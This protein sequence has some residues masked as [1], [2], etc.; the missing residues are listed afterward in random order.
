M[1]WSRLVVL[2]VLSAC[3][4]ALGAAPVAPAAPANPCLDPVQRAALRCPDLHMS[5]PFDLKLD[6]KAVRGRVVLRAGNSINSVGAGPAE[7]HGVR[8]S[9]YRM[10]ARQR[11]YKRGGGRIAVTTGAGLYFKH[12]PGQGRYWKWAHA[13]RFELWRRDSTGTRTK[14]VRVGP[15]A[16]Y[17]L[18]DLKHTR[19]RLTR[20]PRKARYPGCNRS[21]KTRRITLGTSVGWSDVYPASYPEQWIDVTG[22]RGCFDYEHIADPGN[23]IFES[24]EDN[25]KGYVTVRLPFKP[26][27]QNCP[28]RGVQAPPVPSPAP[29]PDP[30][31]Y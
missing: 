13:A 25:N 27:R 7:L 17:C 12:V 19:R 26:G 30:Y 29:A 9:R 21:A 3:A 28:G 2:A 8:S 20:S 16:V 14:R 31:S 5:K 4:V 24:D 23:G 18:R 10:K 22:L 15:K 1:T 6:R 11:I